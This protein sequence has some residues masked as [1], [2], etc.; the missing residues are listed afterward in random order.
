MSFVAILP[1]AFLDISPVELVIIGIAALLLFGERLPQ[2][3]RSFGKGMYEFKRSMSDASNEFQ[4]EMQAA[5]EAAE[6]KKRHDAM[7]AV[8]TTAPA[9]TLAPGTT[10]DPAPSTTTPDSST[11]ESGKIEFKPAEHSVAHEPQHEATP[12]NPSPSMGEAP[13]QTP[14]STPETGVVSP[15]PEHKPQVTLAEK[16]AKG[17]SPQV[18]PTLN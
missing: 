10:I 6:E 8:N 3:A 12:E 1:V 7:M 9:L 2:V 5:A 14:L 13:Q 17:P 18:D 11:P 16:L 4:R 15:D